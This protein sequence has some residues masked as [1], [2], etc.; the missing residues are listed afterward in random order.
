MSPDGRPGEPPS[1]TSLGPGSLGREGSWSSQPGA[2]RARPADDGRGSPGPAPVGYDPVVEARNG[3]RRI[4]GAGAPASVA[5]RV[6]VVL[7]A[8]YWAYREGDQIWVTQRTSAERPAGGV[9]HPV[10]KRAVR[11]SAAALFR[12]MSGGR[13]VAST[14]AMAAAQLAC[15]RWG[16]GGSG[17]C[18]GAQTREPEAS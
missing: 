5:A 10:D 12:E 7:G 14:A 18:G 16:R 11:A 13:E 17:G 6:A 1:G 4:S 8:L 15:L 2:E 3:W 9:L